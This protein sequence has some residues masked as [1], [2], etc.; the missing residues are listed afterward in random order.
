MEKQFNVI[1]SVDNSCCK[2][3]GHG[4]ECEKFA[5]IYCDLRIENEEK[6]NGDC[7]ENL[8]CNFFKY[9]SEN[10]RCNQIIESFAEKITAM[11][12]DLDPIC[13]KF[14][15]DNFNELLLKI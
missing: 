13:N 1:H 6:F 2:C 10:E 4:K 15:N 11:Q 7:G 8:G 14:V 12:K 5:W 9:K 3:N